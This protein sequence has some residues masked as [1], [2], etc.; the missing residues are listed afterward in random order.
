MT[1]TGHE[2][3]EPFLME[4]G[5]FPRISRCRPDAAKLYSCR[6]DN[7]PWAFRAMISKDKLLRLSSPRRRVLIKLAA[8][9]AGCVLSNSAPADTIYATLEQDDAVVALDGV[10]GRIEKTVKVGKRPR[11]IWPGKDG[12]TLYVALSDENAIAALDAATLEP[13]GRLPVDRDPKTFALNPAETLLFASNDDDRQLTV[14]DVAKRQVLKR[15]A[16]GREPEGV[17]VSPDGRT[18]S[19][20]SAWNRSRARPSTRGRGPRALPTTACNSG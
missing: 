20:G 3:K 11:G 16:V 4:F 10:S 9:L 5:K 15:I 8:C 2:N 19:T 17:S 13:R 12:H 18:G 14:V 7:Q 6:P 1:G